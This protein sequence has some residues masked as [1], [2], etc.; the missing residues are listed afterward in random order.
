VN[1]ICIRKYA[2]V[3]LIT[4]FLC[5]SA[6]NTLAQKTSS[7]TP[8]DADLLKRIS[9]VSR[10]TAEELE[11]RDKLLPARGGA[12]DWGLALSGGGI[13]SGSFSIGVMKALYDAGILDRVDAIST[14]SGGG[15]ASYWVFGLYDVSGGK[16][17]GESAFGDDVFLRNTC[18][19]QTHSD[20]Y[21][22]GKMLGALFH[23][24]NGAFD[25][26]QSSIHRTFGRQD[27][28]LENR[29]IDFYDAEIRS[30]RV[31]YFF[32][33]TTMSTSE[34]RGAAQSV[35]LT[36]D[37][38]GNPIL[39]YA[40]WLDKSDTPQ[41]GEATALSA[42]GLAFKLKQEIA[43]FSPFV[44]RNKKD[45]PTDV[46]LYDG[47]WSENSGALPLIR[48]GVKNVIVVDAEHD[49]D[50][51]Y[52]AYFK[53]KWILRTYG[54]DLTV[55][56]I[57]SAHGGEPN[58]PVAVGKA[59]R[60]GMKPID[61]K[62]YWLKMSRPATVFP[63]AVDDRLSDIETR[64]ARLQELRKI[65]PTGVAAAEQRDKDINKTGSGKKVSVTCAGA[66]G[67]VNPDMYVWLANSYGYWLRNSKW[68]EAR[69]LGK[70]AVYDFP[71]LTTYDQSYF[72]DQMEAFIALG[73]L[74]G[75]TLT[76]FF[77]VENR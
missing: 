17:F 25:K 30:G 42:A 71:H 76:E 74:E 61:T 27:P 77:A 11:D 18:E 69:R 59:T 68:R 19:L 6:V 40:N 44:L 8:P 9:P 54:I 26:Y 33:N 39:G 29:L 20:M 72:A 4:S 13:R 73:F 41:L 2:P 51:K 7:S 1:L 15:L 50:Y 75:R 53:L 14:V 49:P 57:E 34:L 63:K 70:G 47:G 60:N 5:A 22:F 31:P 48:R 66:K 43:N 46:Y 64:D 52:E 55:E 23:S 35:E 37:H 21:S 28:Q 56:S 45:E 67:P 16:K 65:Y 3:I 12:V 36:S 32:I 58:A 38:I 62:V 10:T 24:R